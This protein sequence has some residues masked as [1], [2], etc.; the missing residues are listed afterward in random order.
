MTVPIA[1]FII[2]QFLIK[3]KKIPHF[4]YQKIKTEDMVY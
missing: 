4:L 3:I 2:L 1:L